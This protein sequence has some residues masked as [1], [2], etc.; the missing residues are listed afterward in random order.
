M[1]PIDKSNNNHSVNF[2]ANPPKNG[3][4]KVKIKIKS[5]RKVNKYPKNQN[6]FLKLG[7]LKSEN[8]TAINITNKINKV[9]ITA[10]TKEGSVAAIKK[11]NIIAGFRTYKLIIETNNIIIT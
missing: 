9:N 1:N 5:Q 11:I 6:I 7:M 8:L 10:N 3:D 4:N 2:K